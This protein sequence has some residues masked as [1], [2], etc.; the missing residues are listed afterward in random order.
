MESQNKYYTPSIEEFHIGFEYEYLGNNLNT[1]WSKVKAEWS[2]L[3]IMFD[4]YEHE[5]DGKFEELYRVKYLD[6]ED[7]ESL[8]FIVTQKPS[9]SWYE[10]EYDV[11][12]KD[13]SMIDCE[14]NNIDPKDPLFIINNIT[15]KIKNKLELKKLI[16]MLNINE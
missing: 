11:T 15:F 6:K 13:D 4:D 8:G 10:G 16:K 14:F 12:N 1:E 9:G 7:I 5:L 3:D 2:D